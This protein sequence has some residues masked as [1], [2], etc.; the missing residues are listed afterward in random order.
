M[1]RAVIHELAT[2]R[3]VAQHEDALL[4]G[5]PGTGKSEL[6]QALGRAV[7]QQGYRIR[8]R[9]T[10]MLLEEITDATLDGTRKAYL[11]ELA[12]VLRA[13]GSV[14]QSRVYPEVRTAQLAHQSRPTCAPRTQQSRTPLVSDAALVVAGVARSQW[15]AFRC[16]PRRFELP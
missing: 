9:E 14:T 7:I 3:F 1:N 6:A 4:L 5:P 16:P 2:G 10:H 12:T 15:P 13:P 11:A 8:Y